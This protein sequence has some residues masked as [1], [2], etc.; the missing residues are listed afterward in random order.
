MTNHRSS[1]WGHVIPTF[2]MLAYDAGCTTVPAARG[3][4]ID[5]PGFGKQPQPASDAVPFDTANK[6]TADV[7]PA[8][9]G[10][11]NWQA[12]KF[13]QVSDLPQPGP[14]DVSGQ[15]FRRALSDFKPGAAGFVYVQKQTDELRVFDPK[16]VEVA[17]RT[18]SSGANVGADSTAAEPWSLKLK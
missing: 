2:V 8:G 13:V 14:A 4:V 9:K 1:G 6:I 5:I 16:M 7:G 3:K 11:D 18:T 12:W 10:L 15:W 17:S